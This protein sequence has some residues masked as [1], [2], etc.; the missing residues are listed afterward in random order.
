MNF[1]HFLL[2]FFANLPVFENVHDN[3]GCPAI[4][5]CA[6]N[7]MLLMWL[8]NID[9]VLSQR[10]LFKY[11]KRQSLM[12]LQRIDD[13]NVVYPVEIWLDHALQLENFK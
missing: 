5:T 12:T 7:V 1:F 6:E 10:H 13:A 4:P 3:P 9:D 2:E 8:V 11:G